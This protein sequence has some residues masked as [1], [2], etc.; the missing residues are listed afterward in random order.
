MRSYG[1]LSLLVGFLSAVGCAS[2][3][4]VTSSP[5]LSGNPSLPSQELYGLQAS[6]HLRHVCA[7]SPTSSGE[8]HLLDVELFNLQ[9]SPK[10]NV[11]IESVR[12]G[13]FQARFTPTQT[14][15]L[16]S[17]G[18]SGEF[19]SVAGWCF[20]DPP[21]STQPLEVLV[22]FEPHGRRPTVAVYRWQISIPQANHRQ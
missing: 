19:P 9:S 13:A 5:A 4:I 2:R 3:A 20:S 10:Y 7:T 12:L 21:S 18:S 1:C 8:T 14:V 17:R 11:G 16:W 15:T 6:A 22:R